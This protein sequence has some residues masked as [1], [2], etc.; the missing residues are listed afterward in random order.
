MDLKDGEQTEVKGSAKLPYIVKNT[1]GVF[2]CSCIAWK[3]QSQP[4]EKR[5]CKHIRKVRGDEAESARIGGSLVMKG[6]KTKSKV[7]AV[8]PALLLAEK[9]TDA[10]DPTGYWMSEKLDGVRAYW[11]GKRLISRLGNEFYAPDWFL[12]SMPQ[13]ALD[14]ELFMGRKMF[15]ETVS[16]VR[17]QDR[18]TTWE[19]I[20]Y[21]VFDSPSH[22]GKFE[23]RMWDI[24]TLLR[25]D[26]IGKHIL[27]VPQIQCK[28]LDHLLKELDRVQK[29]GGEGL[30][31][32]EPKSLYEGT[33]SSTLLKV[34]TFLDDE[35]VVTDYEKGKGRHVGRTGALWVTWNKKEFKLGTGLSDKE[36]ENPPK[37]GTVV[38]FKY[39]ELSTDGIPRFPVYMG[40]RIDK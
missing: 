34:K 9:W 25:G 16:I 40:Q 17:R 29:L 5:T 21:L 36:R 12:D 39:Q 3:M 30:M 27:F 19:K 31:L 7:T 2:S 14:G 33:R 11:D 18:P 38:S 4:I 1:G 13:V 26:L 10:V 23:D 32:R 8:P 15:Q 37:V 20:K 6:A 22:K 35:A 24:E 28:G